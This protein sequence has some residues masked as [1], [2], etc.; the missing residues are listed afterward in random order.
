MV[1]F[2]VYLNR[3]VFVMD[4]SFL[5]YLQNICLDVECY[6][7]RQLSNGECE[8]KHSPKKD[9]SACF[10]GFIKLTLTS[11]D[12]YIDNGDINLENNIRDALISTIGISGV[13]YRF[14]F[15][16]HTDK[17]GVVD[18]LI[19]HQSII[20][21]DYSVTQSSYV[22]SLM[23]IDDRII[24]I[25]INTDDDTKFHLELSSYNII[26]SEDTATI[27]IQIKS[28]RS[29]TQLT[30]PVQ[31]SD[32]P[33][34]HGRNISV[35]NKLYVCPFIKL[36]ANEIPSEIENGFLVI[37]KRTTYGAIVK[38]FSKWEYDYNDG[39]IYV[40]L[41][42]FQAV[43]NTLTMSTFN[44]NISAS[45]SLPL[46]PK[47]ILSLVCICLSIGSLLVTI[48]TY[49]TCSVLQSQP[50]INNLILC[51][52]L[53]LAQTVYQFGVG[54]TTLP[55]VTCSMIGMVCH[56]M[57]LSV[58]FSMNM[59]CIRMFLI[60]KRHAKISARFKLKQT[61]INITYVICASTLFVVVNMVVS[62]V[63]SH[64]TDIGYGGQVCYFSSN[65]MQ[66]L[67]FV[68]PSAVTLIVNIVLFAYVVYRIRKVG[69]STARVN[70]ERNYLSVYIRLS[71]LTGLTWIFGFLQ[72]FL[73]TEALEYLFI[74]F[75]AGQGVFIMIA[76][77]FNKRTM[78]LLCAKA[79]I[80][81]SSSGRLD[82]T[83]QET[84]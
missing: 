23:G 34:C 21:N 55:D 50:G 78:S 46:H 47:H 5:V 38:T 20:L 24:T 19:V 45:E 71:T 22:D 42:D 75:N 68:V 53:L 58:M 44:M 30:A 77:M 11:Y 65:V 83:H 8:A 43:Y 17:L 70:K 57:W 79:E 6:M 31:S 72:I 60:F 16:Y 2:S 9:T 64:G 61:V 51:V 33:N 25:N 82:T 14:L 29:I 36:N 74:I 39:T 54:Q 59:C 48:I 49:C 67:T 26:F 56:F 73:N 62:V 41:R 7:D 40:C 81:S 3:R 28:D 37:R 27:D 1:K 80:S 18:Y 63:T 15:F 4:T 35:I 52:F 66:T 69:V 12:I 10:A 32:I 84:L 13:E 76:F